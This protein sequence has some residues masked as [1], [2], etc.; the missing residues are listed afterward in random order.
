MAKFGVNVPEGIA[1]FTIKEVEAAA[2]KLKDEAGE[3]CMHHDLQGSRISPES[4]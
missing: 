1:A 2:D 3:V 4:R